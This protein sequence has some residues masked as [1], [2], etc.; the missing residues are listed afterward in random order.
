MTPPFVLS[1]TIGV[2]EIKSPFNKPY[3]SYPTATVISM[4]LPTP[5][6]RRH[7]SLSSLLSWSRYDSIPPILFAGDEDHFQRERHRELQFTLDKLEG[8]I[9]VTPEGHFRRVGFE[10]PALDDVCGLMSML[11]DDLLNT[12]DDQGVE[13]NGLGDLDY[14]AISDWA[15]G[16]SS[17]GSGDPHG[18]PICG[19]NSGSDG[20][21]WMA[22]GGVAVEVPRNI[23]HPAFSWSPDTE[24]RWDTSSRVSEDS[25][26]DEHTR[27][28]PE[29]K[30]N[31]TWKAVGRLRY[32]RCLHLPENILRY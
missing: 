30:L 16:Q 5:S 31:V 9:R 13:E 29:P 28:P 24:E 20:V 32:L 11:G 14:H 19:D 4:S 1:V 22:T 3:Y 21:R 26:F 6:S 8:R 2:R 23:T 10:D 25:F 27:C 18:G 17:T 7:R 12:N 15:A